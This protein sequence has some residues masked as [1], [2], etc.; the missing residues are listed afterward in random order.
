MTVLAILRM[1]GSLALVVGLLVLGVWLARK[2]GLQPAG[3][4]LALVERLPVDARRAF[5]LVRW[6]AEEH[7]LLVAPEGQTLVACRPIS[8]DAAHGN[9]APNPNGGQV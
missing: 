5:V 4:R 7:L 6:D 1:L 3:R 9:P 8:T 2:R